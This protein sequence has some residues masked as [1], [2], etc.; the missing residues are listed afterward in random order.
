[1]T[2]SGNDPHGSRPEPQPDNP[3]GLKA[4]ETLARFLDEDGWFPRRMES[5]HSFTMSYTGQHGDLRCYAMVRVDLEEFLFYALA[6]IKIPEQVRQSVAEY[7]TRA[8]YGLRI[9]N[10]ELDYADGE[11]RYKSSLNFENQEL[12]I[13]LISNTIYPAVQTLDRYLPGLLR[14]SYGGATPFEA[15]EEIESDRE[16]KDE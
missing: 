11:V 4:F 3:N 2:P 9:G 6:P 8:N 15:I 7:L 10:F 14:V 12:T 5:R 16:D 13:D 1:M